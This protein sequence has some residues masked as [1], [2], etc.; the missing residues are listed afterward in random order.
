MKYLEVLMGW[1][2]LH[3]FIIFWASSIDYSLKI[4]MA[5]FFVGVFLILGV[6]LVEA[7]RKDRERKRL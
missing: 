3:L 4:V 1:N 7:I 2:V 6:G 5:N